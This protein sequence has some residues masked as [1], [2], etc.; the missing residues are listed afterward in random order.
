VLYPRQNE[1]RAVFD[2]GG[3]WSFALDDG[4]VPFDPGARLEGENLAVP[5]SYNDQR[6]EL[7]YRT[8]CGAAWYQ[9]EALVPRF[10]EGQRLFLRMGAVTH[11]AEVFLDGKQVCSHRGGFLPFE[12]EVTGLLAPGVPSLLSIRCD[13]RIGPDTLP[14][15]NDGAVAFFGSDN[16]G[17]PSVEAVKA[18]LGTR[19][20]PNFDFFNYAGIHRS[21]LLYTTPQ[22]YIASI[23]VEATA[24]GT[25]RYR[26]GVRGESRE[27]SVEILDPEGAVAASGTAGPDTEGVLKVENARLWE[28]RPGTPWLYRLRCRYR[29][30]VVE[31]H[32]GFRSVEVRGDSFLINGRPFY[33]RGFGKHEDSEMH[34]RGADTVRDVKDL[35]LMKWIGANSFRTSH[36]PYDESV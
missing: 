11:D 9:R 26:I 24:D 21:V 30:D 34:G 32:F 36:Y 15:G 29:E 1:A 7:R 13:N 22:E 31:Q 3:I 18:G 4:R 25:V 20:V 23:K 19:N 6:E 33:F 28:P 12:V 35:S 8:H 17:V 16:A 10:A 5:A 27:L 2:L 14:V